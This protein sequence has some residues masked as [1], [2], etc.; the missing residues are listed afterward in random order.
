MMDAN[1]AMTDLSPFTEEEE[2]FRN[3]VRNFLD[4]ELEPNAD[5]FL[6]DIDYDRQFWRKAGAAGL[7]GAVIPE[8]YGGAGASTI[9]GVVMAQEL[10]RSAGGATV[11]SSLGGDIATH[12]LVKGGTDAQLR[13]WAPGILTGEVIQC[14]P[15]T[16]AGAGSDATAIRTTAVRDGDHYVI[17]GTK[18]YTSTGNKAHLLYVVAKT[19]PTQRGRGMSIFLVEADTPGITRRRMATMG[20][21]AYD[22]AEFYF[23]DLR[24]PAENMFLGEGRAM[25]ILMST[26]G[27]DRLE[28]SARALGEAELAFSLAMDF[29][30]QRK[31]FGQLV[32]DFQ[33]TQFKLAEMKTD[34]EVGRAFLWDNIRKY[35]AGTF[36][37]ADGAMAKL[38][39]PE[40]SA[41]VVDMALQMFG[42]SGFMEEMPISKL[43]RGNRLHRL[44]A[45]TSELQK[46]AIA[47]TF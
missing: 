31:A 5:K 36:T 28:I 17:N 45:G 12:I 32:F 2:M 18:I 11:G 10:G 30:K 39:I 21:P 1:V 13:K 24:V 6:G 42:G 14:M 22:L 40:M 20:F 33:T 26:F 23:D 3:T 16:E 47:R 8:A 27:V 25:E 44:Y 35:R 9:C 7:L 41:R 34:I 15:L 46:V 4:R 43:Y 29:V 19:D 38:W 37:L